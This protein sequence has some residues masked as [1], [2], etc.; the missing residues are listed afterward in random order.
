VQPKQ[1]HQILCFSIDGLP[2]NV[3]PPHNI[4]TTSNWF[5]SA[6]Y[7]T[8]EHLNPN[9][10]IDHDTTEGEITEQMGGLR[11]MLSGSSG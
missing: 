1:R 5:T 11:S 9:G 7:S 8:R 10:C 4:V 6:L 2:Q 3:G